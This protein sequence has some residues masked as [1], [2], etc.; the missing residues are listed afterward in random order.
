MDKHISKIPN[1][2][3]NDNTKDEYNFNYNLFVQKKNNKRKNISKTYYSK[4]SS[5]NYS[6]ENKRENKNSSMEIGFKA[7]K[8]NI[9][10]LSSRLNSTKNINKKNKL[11]KN[12]YNYE[13]C[14]TDCNCKVKLNSLNASHKKME[15]IKINKKIKIFTN[16]EPENKS[17]ILCKNNYIQKPLL[18][19]TFRKSIN[20]IDN[21]YIKRKIFVYSLKNKEKSKMTSKNNSINFNNNSNNFNIIKNIRKK[22]YSSLKRKSITP[23]KNNLISSVNDTKPS[24]ISIKKRYKS[25]QHDSIKIENKL[26]I[27]THNRK[28]NILEDSIHNTNIIKKNSL[29][30]NAKN[31][32]ISSFICYDDKNKN[33]ISSREQVIEDKIK[34]LNNEALKFK[35]ER[36]K[37]KDIKNEYEKL[38]KKLFEN[39]DDF[40]KKKEEFEKYKQNEINNLNKERKNMLLDNKFIMTT[41]MQNKSLELEVKKNEE[42]IAQLKNQINELLLIIKNKDTE[43]KN[44]QKI[45][46]DKNLVKKENSIQNKKEKNNGSDNNSLVNINK[47]EKRTKVLNNSENNN[48]SKYFK[49][50]KINKNTKDF[51]LLFNNNLLEQRNSNKIKNNDHKNKE[52]YYSHVIFDDQNKSSN[53]ISYSFNNS[54]KINGKS[55]E[56]FNSNFEQDSN[57]NN[58][59]NFNK[60]IISKLKISINTNSKKIFSKIDSNKSFN[61]SSIIKNNT[62]E[63]YQNK[64]LHSNQ[65]HFKVNKN[66]RSSLKVKAT[67]INNKINDK[68][69]HPIANNTNLDNNSVKNS[70]NLK[71]IDKNNDLE[72]NNYDFIIP[73]KYIE[74][75]KNNNEIPEALNAN[76]NDNTTFYHNNDG[77]FEISYNDGTSIMKYKEGKIERF[78]ND[79]KENINCNIISQNSLNNKT[80]NI[81]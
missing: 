22:I 32:N 60:N 23:R 28:Y 46:N 75:N 14:H 3:T 35:E 70:F 76:K 42:I 74:I 19:K 55:S 34:E 17:L 27:N 12:E 51:S 53:N 37:V 57:Y 72:R 15:S 4:D 18:F 68:N 1:L 62:I 44:L 39:I 61:N 38:Q 48:N 21:N 71:K 25:V 52:L 31:H 30:N 16:F 20:T 73:E 78:S 69:N 66:L 54:N 9:Y 63:N 80:N 65:I 36:Q 29:N 5:Q 24:K 33:I 7:E 50:K 56:V 59:N 58:N 45:I 26:N 67:L 2:I 40:T 11:I 10:S 81:I 8:E 6:I 77:N 13:I 79:N 49:I 41:K 43:I 47:K 64:D